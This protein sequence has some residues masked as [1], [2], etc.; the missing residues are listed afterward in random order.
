M[1]LEVSL[2]QN[3]DAACETFIRTW[4]YWPLEELQNALETGPYRLFCAKDNGVCVGA[5]LILLSEGFSDVMYLYTSSEHRR[6]KIALTL[7]KTCED[8]LRGKSHE[9]FLEVRRDNIPAQKLYE[10]FGM[11]QVSVRARYYK[12]GTDAWIYCK[13]IQ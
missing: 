1:K 5:I 13:D 10:A 7:L 6:K 3:L 11:K 9:L 2:V 12:D 8:F 4:D